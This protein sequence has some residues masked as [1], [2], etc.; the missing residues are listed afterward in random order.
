[1]SVEFSPY[2]ILEIAEQIERNGIA[3]YT[4]AARAVGDP[5][6]VEML[7]SL[8]S[9]EVGH[10]DL[11][12]DMRNNLSA[13][14]KLPTVFDPYDEMGSYLKSAADNVVFIA[15]TS[16]T[17]VIGPNPTLKGIL[18]IALEREKD[19]V[20]FYSGIRDMVPTE[21]GKSKVD[22]VIREEV[23]HVGMIQRKLAELGK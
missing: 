7:Q 3:F 16:A 21:S 10:V 14:A 19:A 8:A 11:F 15:Q 1:M 20:V 2:E 6:A 9:W 5:E 18:E 13:D 23:T 17:Q 22:G 12:I 4:A